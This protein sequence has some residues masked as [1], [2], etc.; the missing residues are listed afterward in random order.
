MQ[1]SLKP[2]DGPD[3]S[4]LL[5]ALVAADGSCAHNHA[6]SLTVAAAAP[7]ARATADLAD[8]AHYLCLL[9]GRFPGVIDHAAT[10]ITDNAAR[11]WLL[12]AADAFADERAYITRVSVALGP[13]PSTQGHDSCESSVGQQRHALDMLAQSDR[14]GCA[15]GAALALTLDWVAIR[16]LLDRAALRAGLEPRTCRLPTRE[17]SLGV[18]RAIAVDD[19]VGRALQ[20][21]ARQLIGQHRGMWDLLKARAEIRAAI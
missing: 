4:H 3:T 19:Q 6:S 16:T 5:D 18:A 21:G 17:D 8:A 11:K 2:D 1:H 13:M 7:A 20:F 14:R 9:H 12:L 10:R 15:M